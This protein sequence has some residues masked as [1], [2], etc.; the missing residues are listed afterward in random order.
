MRDLC[1]RR[2]GREPS[3]DIR[4][5]AVVDGRMSSESVPVG[6]TESTLKKYSPMGTF[7]DFLLFYSFYTYMLLHEKATEHNAELTFK[8]W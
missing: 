1:V 2:A 5:G 8:R 4:E 7:S 6:V 3:A